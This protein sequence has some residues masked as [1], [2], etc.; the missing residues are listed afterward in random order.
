MPRRGVLRLEL[1][2]RKASTKH[3]RKSHWYTASWRF[4]RSQGFDLCFQRLGKRKRSEIAAVEFTATWL[5][6]D[7]GTPRPLGRLVSLQRLLSICEAEPTAGPVA[8]PVAVVVTV[9][10]APA[11][12]VSYLDQTDRGT[13]FFFLFFCCFR[14]LG[15]RGAGGKGS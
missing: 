2:I 4:S 11:P 12:F 13:G 7:H 8:P 5:L 10:T 15:R 1:S 6:H 9:P 14:E 3:W